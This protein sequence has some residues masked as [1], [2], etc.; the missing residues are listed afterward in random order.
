M[1]ILDEP[2]K[3][4]DLASKVEVYNIINELARIGCAI[5]F[6]SS[7]F[8]ELIGMCDRILVLREGKK[9]YEFPKKEMDYDKILKSAM[10]IVE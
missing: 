8:S 2:T 6:I 7:E 5:I 10:G 9:V 4:L 3:G 1:F